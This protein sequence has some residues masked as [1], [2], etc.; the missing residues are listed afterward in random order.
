MSGT[1]P[2]PA[3][4]SSACLQRRLKELVRVAPGDSTVPVSW[5]AELLDDC[6]GTEE[7]YVPA[8]FDDL[9]VEEAAALVRRAPSTVRTWLT[10]GE[11]VPGAYKLKGREWRIPRAAFRRYLDGGSQGCENEVQNLRLSRRASIGGWRKH[12]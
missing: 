12:V 11:G 2:P 9:S 10:S 5:I 8:Q 4:T 3:E 7:E 6:G 1:K